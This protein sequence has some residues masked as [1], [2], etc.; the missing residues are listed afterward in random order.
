MHSYANDKFMTN[1]SIHGH[2]FRKNGEIFRARDH[3]Q[4]EQTLKIY[5]KLPPSVRQLNKSKFRSFLKKF[6]VKNCFYSLKEFYDFKFNIKN[7][8]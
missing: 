5:N 1:S 7:S 8:L 3:R 6:L 2:N 4:V